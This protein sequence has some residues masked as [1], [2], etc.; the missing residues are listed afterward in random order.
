MAGEVP[1]NFKPTGGVL[2]QVRPLPLASDL[3]PLQLLLV[4]LLPDVCLLRG[5]TLGLFVW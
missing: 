5:R 1:F 2:R 4:G 3:A